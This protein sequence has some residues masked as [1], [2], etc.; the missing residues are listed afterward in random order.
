VREPDQKK[1]TGVITDRDF[2]VVA[3]LGAAVDGV[4]QTGRPP[5]R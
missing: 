5:E 1:G 4:T 2:K 3:R